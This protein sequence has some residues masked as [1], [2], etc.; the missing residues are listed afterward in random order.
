[1]KKLFK[2]SK[3]L[4]AIAGVTIL[5]T[6]CEKMIETPPPNEILVEDAIN[7]TQD[8][9]LLLNGSYNEIANTFGGF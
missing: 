4:W 5:G 9:Q 2:T 3:Y 8:L 6:S 1:M 7:N